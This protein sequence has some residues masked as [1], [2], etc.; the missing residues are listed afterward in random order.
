MGVAGYTKPTQPAEPEVKPV[1]PVQPLNPP[2]KTSEYPDGTPQETQNPPEVHENPNPIKPDQTP[3][4]VPKQPEVLPPPDET[5]AK[6][7]FIIDTFHNMTS[8]NTDRC[9]QVVADLTGY[10]EGSFCKVTYYKM[11]FAET[12]NKGVTNDLDISAHKVHKSMLKIHGFEI[13]LMGSF[14]FEHDTAETVNKMTGE[15]LTYPGFTP[16]K[17]DKFLY[18][19]DSGKFGEFEITEIPTRTSIKSST[20]FKIT[21]SLVKWVDNARV[22][23]L[24]DAVFTEAYFD[25]RRFLNEAGALLY[26]AEY[27]D[28]KFMELQ[29]ARMVKYYASK[30]LD[31]QIMFSYM[32]PDGVYDP[33]VTDFMMKTIDYAESLIVAAQLYRDAPGIETSIWRALLSETVPLEAVPTSSVIAVRTL[34]SKSVMHNSLLNKKYLMWEEGSDSLAELFERENC[35]GEEHDPCE[36]VEI[37]DF[38]DPDKD[39]VIGDLLLHIH[40]H[41]KECILTCCGDCN[42]CGDKVCDDSNGALAYLL[43]GSA[44]YR[45]LIRMFLRYRKINMNY[46]R[47][48]IERVYKLPPIQQFYKMPVYIFLA[49]TAVRYIHGIAGIYE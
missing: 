30:F 23:E 11:Q 3:E 26:H 21:F 9:S 5:L 24:D 48:C 1:T 47:L 28:M 35:E 14:N 39:R 27:V 44:E 2:K 33:Y 37:S 8:V 7:H 10:A 36:D 41:F 34:G 32:R 38:E 17:G 25:K 43:D 22:K 6:Q 42:C 45:E 19:I 31:R 49:R 46:L 12:N 40:P 29:S 20:Y 16:S 13:R 15:A 4:V 18:E